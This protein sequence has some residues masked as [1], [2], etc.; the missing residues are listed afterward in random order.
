M[1]WAPRGLLHQ[2]QRGSEARQPQPLCA[3]SQSVLTSSVCRPGGGVPS[4]PQILPQVFRPRQNP[5]PELQPETSPA[6]WVRFSFSA[7]S[8]G[9]V[10]REAPCASMTCLISCV[11]MF[12]CWSRWHL[13]GWVP[14]RLLWR[15]DGAEM[16]TLPRFLSF[17]CWKAEPPVSH[18]QSPP[19]PRGQ[20]VCGDVPAW[21]V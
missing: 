6:Q 7:F 21:V 15:R 11:I 2:L 13:C 16:S 4:L 10:S 12:V 3:I 1:L 14:N 17:V 19:I 18:L 8:E 9:S 5:L 20:R